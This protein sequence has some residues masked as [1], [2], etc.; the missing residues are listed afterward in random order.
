MKGGRIDYRIGLF[1]LGIAHV[2]ALLV[3]IEQHLVIYQHVLLARFV[4]Q[5]GDVFDELGIVLEKRV[6]KMRLLLN[7]RTAYEQFTRFFRRNAAIA[8][9]AAWHHGQ[10]VQSHAL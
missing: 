6:L 3:K 7:Q 1:T 5:L 8:D 10:A 9:Q 4:F 2:Y